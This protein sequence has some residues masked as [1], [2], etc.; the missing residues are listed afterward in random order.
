MAGRP[1]GASGTDGGIGGKSETS[2]SGGAATGQAGMGGAAGTHGGGGAGASTSGAAGTGGTAGRGAATGNGGAAGSGGTAGSGDGGLPPC[3]TTGDGLDDA[4]SCVA[5]PAYL[6]FVN[7]SS[8]ET[9]DVYVTGATNPVTVGLGPHQVGAVGPVQAKVL[10]YEFRASGLSP[11]RGEVTLEANGHFTLVAYLDPTTAP[12]TFKTNAAPQ[13]TPGLCGAGAQVDFGEFTSLTPA[14]VIVLYAT[15]GGTSWTP[16]VSPGLAVGQN[17]RLGMLERR[18]VD[19]VRRRPREGRHADRQVPGGHLHERPELPAVD[20]RRRHHRD[21]QPRSGHQ[22]SE[23]L[24]AQR[25]GDTP[26]P[27]RTPRPFVAQ[28]GHAVL[29]R[30]CLGR[31]DKVGA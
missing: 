14:P 31:G 3:D 23:A 16:A 13:M 12:P 28:P 4:A 15:S 6:R 1:D 17:L 24:T 26:L 18:H 27:A 7:A 19:P 30:A 22:R 9:F 2:G 29:S 5:A 8:T 25:S 20:D 21:R 11:V 10:A